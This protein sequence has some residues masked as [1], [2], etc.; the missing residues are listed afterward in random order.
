MRKLNPS[1]THWIAFTISL[2]V[3]FNFVGCAAL[4]EA[5]QKRQERIKKQ[6]KDRYLTLE[7]PDAQIRASP[8]GLKIESDHYILTFADDLLKH[9]DFDEISE[10]QD[11]G[12]GAL[13]FMESLYKYVHDLFGFEPPKRIRTILHQTYKGTTRLATTQIQYKRSYQNGEILKVVTGIEMNFPLE[14][15]NQKD[16]RAHE[17][18]H[19]FTNIYLLPT[20][21]AEGIAVLVQVEYAKGKSHGKV[22]L[23]DDLKLDADGINAAQTWRGHTDAIGAATS[24][25]SYNYSYS[26][27][28]ELH[29]RFGEDFYPELFR[30]IEEDKLHQRLPGAMSTSM[31]IYYMGQAA[32]QDLVPFFQD[33]KFQTRRLTR[34][35]IIKVI[36]QATE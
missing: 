31:L 34:G 30:L 5:Q 19:A 13:V 14:M 20:W 6:Q 28:S 9:K 11:M 1:N 8:D 7:R 10:R 15:Y 26:I 35:E 3:A 18:T 17:L 16:V 27:V 21:F 33:L 22:D 24:S 23:Y 25:W 4:N 32:G 36:K 29:K 12:R 2:I